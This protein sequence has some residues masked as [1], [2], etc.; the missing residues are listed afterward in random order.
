MKKLLNEFVNFAIFLN[1]SD[2]KNTYRFTALVGLFV[3][4][5]EQEEEHNGMHTDPPN[6]SFRIIAIN[7][8]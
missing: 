5:I 2:H 3:E 7:E 1:N 6:E 8:E 4:F